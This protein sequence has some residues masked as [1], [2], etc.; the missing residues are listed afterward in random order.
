MSFRRTLTH[1]ALSYCET[2]NIVASKYNKISSQIDKLSI[3]KDGVVESL[4]VIAGSS[5]SLDAL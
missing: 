3:I 1:K 5:A 2:I 4:E